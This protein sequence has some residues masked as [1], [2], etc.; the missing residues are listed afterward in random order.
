MLLDNLRANGENAQKALTG[1]I[2]EIDFEERT[3]AQEA[4]KTSIITPRELIPDETKSKLNVLLP[5]LF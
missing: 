5:E 4:V 2:K 1:I 3:E